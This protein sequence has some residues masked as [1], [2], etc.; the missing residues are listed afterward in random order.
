MA[1]GERK[2]HHK[3]L[4]KSIDAKV[5]AITPPVFRLIRLPIKTP[6]TIRNMMPRIT[7]PTIIKGTNIYD[8]ELG[9]TSDG[10]I[11]FSH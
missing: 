11:H 1:V 8:Q 9:T 2:M 3:P 5:K 4:K 6:N 7:A 10:I